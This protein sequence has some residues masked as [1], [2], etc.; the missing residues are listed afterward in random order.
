MM[1]DEG[2]RIY[3]TSVGKGI[4]ATVRMQLIPEGEV[5]SIEFDFSY[6]RL[7][8]AILALIASLIIVGLSLSSLMPPFLLATLSF[9]ALSIISLF[10]ILWMKEELNEFLKNINEILLALESE[11]SRRKLM[12]DKIRWRSASVDAEKLYRELHEKY[13]KTWGSA[14]I[15]EYK[16]REYMDRLGLTRD[17][18][19][20]KVSE[21]E[22]LL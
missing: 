11:Y 22:G 7:I 13:I 4:C 9:V 2:K 1:E 3:E 20:M 12:E 15:L 17:E 19:I 16:I 10:I 21:E 18:A 5:S 8:F 14:F 6:R